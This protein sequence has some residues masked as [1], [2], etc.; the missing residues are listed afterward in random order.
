MIKYQA[1]RGNF[2]EQ[3]EHLQRPSSDEQAPPPAKRSRSSRNR[4]K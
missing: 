2:A 3:S 4:A 1:D